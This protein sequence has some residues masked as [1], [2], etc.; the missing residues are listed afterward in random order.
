MLESSSAAFFLR[1]CWFLPQECL[2]LFL[3]LRRDSKQGR[4]HQDGDEEERHAR[5]DSSVGSSVFFL[6]LRFGSSSSEEKLRQAEEVFE[7]K[8]TEKSMPVIGELREE[9]RRNS[10]S[11]PSSQ[12]SPR[13]FC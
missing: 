11:L 4:P 1:V 9:A 8:K 7:R 10:F 5:R 12:E 2:V 3:S 6:S 13:G